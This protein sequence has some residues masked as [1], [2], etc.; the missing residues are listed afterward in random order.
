MQVF[1]TL[2]QLP[3]RF[4]PTIV[5]V[6]NFDGVHRAHTH[7][8]EEIARRA[9]EQGKRSI[10]VSFEPHPS[11]VLRPDIELRL[12]T[13]TKEKLRLLEV[14]GVDATLI[15]PFTHEL[16]EMLPEH[17]ASHILKDHLQAS[18]VHEGTNFRFGHKASGDVNALL[19]CGGKMGFEVKIYPELRFRGETVSSSR[20]R[21]LVGEGEVSRA[22]HLLG[23]AFGVQSALEHG[24]GYGSKYTVP[25]VNLGAYGDLV[26]GNGVYISRTQ[27]AEE[28]FDS[29]TNVGNRP[30]FGLDSFAVESHLLN[31]H[32]MEISTQTEVKI[33]FLKRLRDE[34]KFPSVEALREQITRDVGQARHYFELL[35]TKVSA[36]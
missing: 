30:T 17:F 29:V 32:P 9:R 21:K 33:Y 24:R 13:P 35:D 18:E 6:G 11:R 26:P 25:T 15:L 36:E 27:L 28:C 7:V 2:D 20:I 23:R 1:H 5:S 8:L 19:E 31:F 3:A 14:S 22:R 34:V 12:L 4:G 10:A 16:S